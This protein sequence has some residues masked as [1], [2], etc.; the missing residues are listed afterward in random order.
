[1][2]KIFYLN[3]SQNTAFINEEL[4]E[5]NRFI[6]IKGK[7]LSVTPNRIAGR[8]NTVDWLIVADNAINF[9]GDVDLTV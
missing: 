8:D 7:I 3:T 2:Q 4:E 6:G 5:I 1:M 9:E